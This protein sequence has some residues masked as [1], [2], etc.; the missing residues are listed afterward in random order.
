[1]A[2]LPAYLGT[3]AKHADG[4]LG[5]GSI[6]MYMNIYGHAINSYAIY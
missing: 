5:N 2:L 3:W 4:G 1:M 6:D